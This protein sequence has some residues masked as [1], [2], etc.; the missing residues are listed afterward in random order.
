MDLLN[1]NELKKLI[2]FFKEFPGWDQ[3]AMKSIEGLADEEII[4]QL[5]NYTLEMKKFK[6]GISNRTT[7]VI[8]PIVKSSPHGEVIISI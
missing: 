3:Q 1:K 7:E 8:G 2:D 4:S 6:N 5:Y